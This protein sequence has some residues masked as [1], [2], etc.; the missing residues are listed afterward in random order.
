M[1]RIMNRYASAAAALAVL[2]LTAC[3]KNTI[4]D[5]TKPVI[6][7]TQVRFFNFGVNAPQLNFYA[8]ETKMA[9]INSS[10]CSPTPTDTVQQRIC[11]ES[12]QESTTGIAYGAVGASG[13]YSVI[14]P[15]PYTLKGT[16]AA[17]TDKNLA[18][19]SL[20]VT[21]DANKVYSFYVSGFYNTTTKTVDAFIVEDPIPAIDWEKA[22]VRFVNAISN[23]SPM[24]L[25]ARDSTT[26]IET[27]IG[28]TGTVAYK[29]AGTYTGI[30]P[31]TY[32]LYTTVAGSGT[33]V[34]KREGV[35]LS[36]GRVYTISARGDITVV[37]T[38]ATNRPFLDNTANR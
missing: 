38:T 10:L 24:T 15:G 14:E 31:G 23:S 12:G 18:V 16:I 27:A 5:I 33:K 21:L 22:T 9:A 13:L 11:R 25:T 29:G 19:A 7:T 3:E 37:S 8:N 28:G 26:K 30:A 32:E 20:P 17:T 36:A 1:S 6:P 2:A 4:V 35:V 34:I